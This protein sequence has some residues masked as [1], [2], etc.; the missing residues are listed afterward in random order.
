MY[1]KICIA[2]LYPKTNE[3]STTIICAINSYYIANFL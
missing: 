3:K 1:C 2:F